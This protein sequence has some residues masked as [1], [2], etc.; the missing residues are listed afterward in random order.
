V[1]DATAAFNARDAGGAGRL[2][3]A[4]MRAA[5]A[6]FGVEL[7]D[8]EHTLL[9]PPP[10]AGD[11]AAAGGDAAAATVDYAEFVRHYRCRPPPV[12]SPGRRW[13]CVRG[14][15]SRRPSSVG[16]TVF[17]CLLLGVQGCAAPWLRGG[18]GSAGLQGALM[19]PAAARAQ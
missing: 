18:G 4:E 10:P 2:A 17:H 6:A 19:R 9:F 7:S 13:R 11:A 12:A 14:R 16:C 1:A 15:A 5:L 8:A 3:P